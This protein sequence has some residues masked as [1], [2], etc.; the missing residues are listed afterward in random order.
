MPSNSLS[1]RR[2]ILRR[3]IVCKKGPPPLGDP[4]DW[5]PAEFDITFEYTYFGEE[6][7]T[8]VSWTV[9]CTLSAT[10]ENFWVGDVTGTEASVVEFT[11]FPATE[12]ADLL[13]SGNN[14]LM[15]PYNAE[16]QG[17][18]IAVDVPSTYVI[19]TWDT[20]SGWITSAKASFT[21]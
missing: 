21:F 4:V 1:K 9:P 3:P 7:E 19:T 14:T 18:P 15:G 16:I 8:T 6:G 13:V 11:F 2:D 5:P 17:I 20:L 10:I 12:T